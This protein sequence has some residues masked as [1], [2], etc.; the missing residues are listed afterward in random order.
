[1]YEEE[2]D[3][4]TVNL[5]ELRRKRLLE[6]ETNDIKDLEI[7]D[8]VYL[9]KIKE[10]TNEDEQIKEKQ[11]YMTIEEK[12]GN[13]LYRYYDENQE[14]LG[15]EK[16]NDYIPTEKNIDKPELN[17][18]IKSLEKNGLS[19]NEQEKKEQ[20]TEKEQ[21]Q[22]ETNKETIELPLDQIVLSDLIPKENVDLN[23][24]H[25]GVTLRNI[26]GLS[27]EYD[28][29]VLVSADQV[30]KFLPAN[31]KI[32]HKDA[33]VAKK[34]NGEITILTENMLEFDRRSG[35]HPLEK[36]E[37]I[38]TDGRIAQEQVTSRFKITNGNG[39][40]YISVG[41]D[42]VHGKE[43]KFSEWSPEKGEYLDTELQTNRIL[44]QDMNQD[45]IVDEKRK[46]GFYDA[47]NKLESI[48][49]VKDSDK[50]GTK[51]KEEIDYEKIY[52]D[53]EIEQAVNEIIENDSISEGY[54]RESVKEYLIK[55]Y[56]E[57]DNLT[58]K[59]AKDYVEKDLETTMIGR[60]REKK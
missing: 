2:L 18:N 44:R 3:D 5:Y 14:L 39:K 51:E 6:I 45:L 53:E 42:E 10:K 47:K 50:N 49:N 16:E 52:D 60:T 22:Q 11:I 54:S 48:E 7:K 27:S 20:N 29:L 38:N 19:L 58:V 46:K 55:K 28:K 41:Y 4:I 8:I 17:T 43:I 34:P 21:E 1:M 37:T 25:N 23:E 9:G 57:V 12:D 13:I 33:F 15:I 56:R 40:Q 32:L 59:E 35:E 31:K 26:L 30:N 36:N 24:Y